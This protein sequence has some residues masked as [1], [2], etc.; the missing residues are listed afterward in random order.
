MFF[1]IVLI[2]GP[3][4]RPCMA[5]PQPEVGTEQSWQGALLMAGSA[6]CFVAAGMA[7]K[8][9]ATDLSNAMIV[10]FRN[11][12]AAVV[13]LPWVWRELQWLHG[14]RRYG[15]HVLRTT[16]SLAAMYCYFGAIAR[17]PLA[18]AVLLQFTSPIFV[19]LFALGLLGVALKTRVVGAAIAGFLG[20]AIVLDP[21]G[22][23]LNSG[24][25]LGLASGAF[26]ALAVIA[27]WVLSGRESAAR[28]VFFFSVFSAAFSA[29]PL[30]WYWQT[31]T[32]TELGALTAVGVFS[33]VAQL[34][35]T[36]ACSV[37]HPDR[38]VTVSYTGVLWA[39]LAGYI[40]WGEAV[41]W[42]FGLGAI[43]IIWACIVATRYQDEP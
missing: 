2:N 27:I 14:R 41:D 10:F 7:V 3:V 36:A 31:P 40:I 5:S 26:S 29:V 18:D 11:A 15:M 28:I 22:A 19:P 9:A 1:K 21:S 16:A 38:V 42:R 37:G 6:L 32:L 39:G 43:A 13:L 23:V 4:Y 34:L 12:V 25:L 8:I 24:A 20:V 33:A 17:I 35:F 30:P